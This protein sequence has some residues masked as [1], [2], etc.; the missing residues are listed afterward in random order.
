MAMRIF[1]YVLAIVNIALIAINFSHF[2]NITLSYFNFIPSEY[3]KY[4]FADKTIVVD[5][6]KINLPLGYHIQEYDPDAYAGPVYN[7]RNCNF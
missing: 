3:F 7:T 6:E 4:L 5:G 2:Q 1:K